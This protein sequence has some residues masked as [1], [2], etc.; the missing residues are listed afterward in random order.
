METLDNQVDNV[1]S[2]VVDEGQ[3]NLP[4]DI[5]QRNA[6]LSKWE[7]NEER[8]SKYFK[9]GKAYGRFDSIESV[10]ESLKNTEDKYAQVMRQ[11]KSQQQEATQQASEP[12]VNVYEVAQPLVEKFMQGNMELTPEIE[13]M[14][15]ERG[16]DIRDVKLAAI[17]LKEQ[18]TKAHNIVG[19]KDTYEAMINWGKENLSEA[20]KADFDKALKTGMGEFAIKGLYAD[21]KASNGQ[22]TTPQRITGDDVG[23][24]ANNRA[25]STRE[26]I[27]RDRAYLNSMQGRSD[28]AARKAHEAR[29]ARTPDHIIY[30]QQLG[31]S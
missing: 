2:Q 25:Y 21:Y 7:L 23:S 14:A 20:Q 15:V 6:D 4:S 26:E 27:L 18:V 3:S 1:E 10:L 31:T 24:T 11:Q 17:E 22:P 9:D 28:T 8:L 16:L 12:E 5:E 30:G 29:L 13:A 19:G